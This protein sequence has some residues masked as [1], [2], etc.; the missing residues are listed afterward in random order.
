MAEDQRASFRASLAERQNHPV[1]FHA[2]LL[3]DGRNRARELIALKKPIAARVFVGTPLDLVQHL[4]AE[5]IERR[6]LTEGQ[7]AYYAAQIARMPRGANQYTRADAGTP[8]FSMLVDEKFPA[9]AGAADAPIDASS[10]AMLSQTEAADAYNVSRRSVQRADVVLEK[11]APELQH[12]VATGKVAVSTAAEIAK[13]MP[14]EQQHALAGMDEDQILA[15]AKR[16]RVERNEKRRGE[17]ADRIA[18]KAARNAALPTGKRFPVIYMDPPTKFAAGD[19]DRSTENHYPTMSEEELARLPVDALAAEDAALFIWTTRPWLRKT[20]R[21]IEG[22]GFDYKT[23]AGWDKVDIGLGFWFQDQLELL[24]VCTRGRMLAPA[25]GAILGP[26]LH[27]EKK[28]EHS[29]KPLWFRDAIARVPEY[30][31]FD[32]LEMFA[33]VDGPMPEGWFAWGNEARVPQ[34]QTLAL[35]SPDGAAQAAQS[36]AALEAA[37]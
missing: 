14:L 11:G 13:G 19:S 24:L 2:G 6:H 31:R 15:E 20:L 9:V 8:T 10:A 36:G 16:I 7:R 12:A 4:N 21:L 29:R 23:C 33:R 32:K 5:N 27:S 22:W 28:N 37:E 30:A 34:Q 3:A 1:L 35:S 18:E 17:R 26:S 25:N